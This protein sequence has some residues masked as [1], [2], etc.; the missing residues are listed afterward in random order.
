VPAKKRRSPQEKKHLSYTRDRRNRYGEND[1]S[2]RKS[3]PRRKHLRHRAG[4]HHQRQLLAAALGPVDED[5]AALVQDRV[6]RPRHGERG[7]RWRKVPDEQLG[8]HVAASL[9]RRADKG[10]SAAETEQAR[11][12][13]VLRNTQIHRSELNQVRWVRMPTSAESAGKLQALW[14]TTIVMIRDALC[15]FDAP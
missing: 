10:I 12:A 11:I 4:R 9:K 5:T 2:S 3:I 7:D 6:T 15:P 1:K 13:K 14:C 8:L